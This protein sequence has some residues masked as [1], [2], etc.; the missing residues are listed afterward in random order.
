MKLLLPW[1]ALASVAFAAQAPAAVDFSRDILPILSD[2]CFHCH[3]PDESSRKAKLRLDTKDGAFRTKDPVIVPGK[4]SESELIARITTRN[5]DDVMPPA[6]SNLKLTARE[7][8]LLKQWIDEGAPWGQHWAYVSP[9]RPAVPAVQSSKSKV[10]SPVD[11]FVLAPLQKEKLEPAPE[12]SRERWLRR[13]TL[14]LTGLPPTLQELDH[15]LAD[16]SPDAHERVVDRLLASPRFGERMATEWLDLARFADTHGYQMD[17]YRPV[18]A[19]RDWVIKAFNQNLPYDQFVTWQVAG[20]LLPNATKEQRL[21]TA[22]NRLHNQNEEGGIVEE[23][24]RV[25]YVVDRVNTFGT[26]FLGMTMECARCHD[27]KYDPISQ[28]DF[29]SLFAFFQNVDEAGQ[30]PYF[31]EPTPT[32]TLLLSTDEQDQK[33]AAMRATIAAK[34]QEL[35]GLRASAQGA[36]NEWL[37]HVKSDGTQSL[38][39]LFTAFATNRLIGHFA[40]DEMISNQVANLASTNFAKAQEGPRLV[41]GK[42]GQAVELSGENGFS[43]GNVGHFNRADAFTLTLWLQTPS[44]APR[45]T[46]L[47]HSK[48]PV[49]AGSRGYELLLENG[50]V[51][52]GLHHMWPGNALKVVSKTQLPTNQWVHV[53]AAYDGSSRARG[54]QLFIN[55]ERVEFEV[56]RDNLWKDITYEGGEPELTLGHRFRDNGFKGGL[57]DELKVFRRAL[58]AVE[59]AEAAGKVSWSNVLAQARASLSPRRGEGL[60][61]RGG[62]ASRPTDANAQT[63]SPLTPA[64]SPLRREGEVVPASGTKAR[65]FQE[66]LFDYFFAHHFEPAAKAR[67]DLHAARDE[68]RRFINPIPEIMAMQELP[69]PKPA[70][71]LK[72]GAYD[73]PGERV[74]ANTPA[75]LPAFPKD[76][77]TNRLGLARWLLQPDNPLMARVTVNR[78]WQMMFGRGLVETA[79]NF[80][81]QGAQPSHPELLDWLAWEFMQPRQQDAG[82]TVPWDLKRMLKLIALSSAYRQSSQASPELL[83][84]DPQNELLA[85]GPARRLTAEML[86]DSALATSGLLVEKIG[87]PS[88]KP[89]Q[90]DG[91]WDIAM[92][93]PKYETSQGEGLYRRSLYTYWKRT[94]PPPTMVTFDAADRSYCTVKRQQTSTPL[95]ALALLNDVQVVEAARTLGERMLKQTDAKETQRVAW[96]FRTIAGRNPTAKEQPVLERLLAEQRALFAAERGSAEKLLRVGDS[97]ADDS[98]DVVELAAATVLAN[99]LLNHDE[100]VMQR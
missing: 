94:V 29:Y 99:A 60:R 53:A 65:P 90:P 77:P 75:V 43:F 55:G 23:E 49:D 17:R 34:E 28:K 2:K 64:L 22:F 19:Y 40:F 13:V 88:V 37:R 100:F 62:Q 14:D 79:D 16:T 87:G 33:L 67:K 58:T 71:V 93:K 38:Q 48:A 7:V 42:F 84:R 26:A 11:A 39:T 24:F 51:A 46:V 3:G 86:R 70:F 69:E 31:V 20:D 78:L 57:V 30:T 25:A 74:T 50:R 85:R 97:K 72:R 41:P 9:K 73:S 59:V 80:G 95:Q 96:L 82:R 52:F 68:Q 92:G 10:R 4:S 54:V 89:Y 76:Q 5:E 35:D 21:A 47:H 66:Q 44:H 91:I 61:V 98:L 12:A 56:V 18:W 8:A 83:A 6:D 1:L 45:M 81:T 36:F 15:F 32:P 27:H 63:K